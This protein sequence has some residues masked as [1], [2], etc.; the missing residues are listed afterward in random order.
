M[1]MQ[2]SYTIIIVS[3][4][5]VLNGIEIQNEIKYNNSNSEYTLTLSWGYIR[6]KYKN[7]KTLENLLNPI[8]LVLIGKLSPSILRWLPICQGFGDFSGFLHYFVLAKLATS[9]IRAKATNNSAPTF[10]K[11]N[12]LD[13]NTKTSLE[14]LRPRI[15]FHQFDRLRPSEMFKKR[16]N[17]Y[18]LTA[19]QT[20]YTSKIITKNKNVN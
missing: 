2:V 8:L 12:Q 20:K 18:H 10:D 13:P 4:N 14:F 16:K 11:R 7:A 17:G 6:P 1:G 5:L 3:Y 9:S 19:K 15:I